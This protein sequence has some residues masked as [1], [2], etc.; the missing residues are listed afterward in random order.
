MG[1]AD[2]D[3][4]QSSPRELKLK[5]QTQTDFEKYFLLFVK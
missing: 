5:T 2:F 3:I 4:S 1:G